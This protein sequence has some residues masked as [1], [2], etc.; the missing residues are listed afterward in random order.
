MDF[1]ELSPAAQRLSGLL[2]SNNSQSS[3]QSEKFNVSGVASDVYFAYEKLRN[4][5]D[6]SHQHLLLR[7][8]IERFLKRDLT[9]KHGSRPK[10]L[11]KDLLTEL[12]NARYFAND[13]IPTT[14]LTQI[15]QFIAD[16]VSFFHTATNSVGVTPQTAARWTYQI[17]SVAIE[18]ILQPQPTNDSLIGFAF[19]HYAEAIERKNFAELSEDDFNIAVFCASMRSIFNS[20]QATTMSVWLSLTLKSGT[21][22]Q[23][24]VKACE[25]VDKWFDAPQTNKLGRIINRYGAP[26]RSINEVVQSNPEITLNNSR[27]FMQL[28]EETVVTQ[29]SITQNKLQKSVKRA[30][31]FIFLT[32]LLTGIAIEIPYDLFIFGKIAYIPFAIT[33]LVPIIYMLSAIFSLRRPDSRNT[34]TIL[35]YVERIIYK[36]DNPIVYRQRARVNP[37]WRT[38]FNVVY[39]LIAFAVLGFV[40][41]GL[42]QAGFH[43]IHAVMFFLFLSG[44]SLLRFR[45]MQSARELEV[46]DRHQ[47]VFAALADFLYLPFIQL[48][49][50]LSDKY[51][52]INLAAFLLDLAIELPLKTS[53][54]TLRNW[55]DFLRDKREEI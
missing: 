52:Q 44:A 6:Y 41:W 4:A 36:T 18:R 30:V 22:I 15:N 46:I 19:N 49:Q 1:R 33:M 34:Q 21:S 17:L 24:F 14:A 31:I 50:V 10:K 13:S 9:L 7:S 32:K 27:D 29:Y 54:R 47:S 5:A 16:Y 37:R 35:N 38:W 43:I 25:Q 28:L 3:E 51:R 26:V 23:D 8:A 53:L 48:G 20:D 42:I 39:A 11:A 12:T 40:I 55:A 2:Q 45:I